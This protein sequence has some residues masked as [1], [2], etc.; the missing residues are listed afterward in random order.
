MFLLS[1]CFDVQKDLYFSHTACAAAPLFT[2][3][4]KP[5]SSL[6]WLVNREEMSRPLAYHE[7]CVGVQ[8]RRFMQNNRAPLIVCNCFT[9]Y[10]RWPA[11]LWLVNRLE[12]SRPLAY[13]VQCVGT[14]ANRRA[15]KHINIQRVF[16]NESFALINPDKTVHLV[17][18]PFAQRNIY[19]FT[20]P[21]SNSLS[22]FP[23]KLVTLIRKKNFDFHPQTHII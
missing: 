13:H 6:L 16:K 18:P 7:Q 3:C 17:P 4:L 10:R 20:D 12:T 19:F 15:T 14:L 2:L 5:E 22:L 8:W 23:S 1:P 21:L 9:E 11:L